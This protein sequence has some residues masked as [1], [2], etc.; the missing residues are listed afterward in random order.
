MSRTKEQRENT[1]HQ[2]NLIFPKCGGKK[3]CRFDLGL[4]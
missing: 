1:K 3:K 4:S 2:N